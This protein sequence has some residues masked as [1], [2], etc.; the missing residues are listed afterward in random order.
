MSNIESR[1]LEVLITGVEERKNQA[2]DL[3]HDVKH[4]GQF[5]DGVAFSGASQVYLAE[6]SMLHQPKAEKQKEDEFKLARAMRDSWMS[7]LRATCRESVSCR[8]MSVFGSSSFKDET[9]LWM[10]DFRAVFR[11][12]QF[13]VFI[14]PLKKRE[15]GRKMKA[16]VLSCIGLAL[17]IEMELEIREANVQPTTYEE[18]LEWEEA[19]RRVD[20]TSTTPER[21]K[22]RKFSAV[23]E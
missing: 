21:P 14:V 1:Y 17:R 11:L 19:T 4:P 15:F 3:R 9:K 8:G 12:H 20:T 7:Q 22:K 13:D 6:A 18:R 23:P 2:A 5:T 16:A 10:M